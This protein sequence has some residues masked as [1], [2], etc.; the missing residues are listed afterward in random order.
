MAAADDEVRRDRS[1]WSSIA[2]MPERVHRARGR[3]RREV[4]LRAALEV[5]GERGVGA[6]THRAVAQ[7][8]DVPVATTTYYFSSLDELLEAALEL[9]VEDEVAKLAAVT[10]RVIDLQGT[11]AEIIAAV[12]GEL[13]HAQ[14]TPQFD[15]Y[16]EASR[17]PSLRPVVARSLAA[18]R[19]LAEEVL[20]RVGARDPE[21]AAPLVVALLDGLS[22]QDAAIGEPRDPARIGAAMQAL[23]GSFLEG[24]PA[25]TQSPL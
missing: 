11:P 12:A 21:L 5:I 15:L 23:L 7:V 2:A 19:T 14:S 4:L 18:Y 25:A 13:A 16:V 8:A 22:V 1:G 10:S 9:H 17:R 3:R 24:Q 20:R 6:T